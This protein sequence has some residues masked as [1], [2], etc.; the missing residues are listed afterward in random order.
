VS[1]TQATGATTRSSGCFGRNPT[2]HSCRLRSSSEPSYSISVVS[3]PERGEMTGL[4]NAITLCRMLLVNALDSCALGAPS[5]SVPRVLSTDRAA[6]WA[7]SPGL[8]ASLGELWDSPLFGPFE[9]QPTSGIWLHCWPWAVSSVGRAPA[10]QAGGHWF[11]PSTAHLMKPLLTRLLHI[12]SE[13]GLRRL[14]SVAAYAGVRVRSGPPGL[15]GGR[16]R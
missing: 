16:V 4:R 6:R 13:R 1:S 15:A 3:L 14:S 12:A 2:V 7:T 10:R 9:V 11:E 5:Q 8:S